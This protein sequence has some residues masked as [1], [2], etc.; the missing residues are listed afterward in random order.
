MIAYINL[1]FCPD[2]DPAGP[3]VDKQALVQTANDVT[4]AYVDQDAWVG[5]SSVDC[6]RRTGT[7]K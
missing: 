1:S 7:V 5:P 4:D 6:R 2:F 3:R